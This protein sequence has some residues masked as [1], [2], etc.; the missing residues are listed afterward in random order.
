MALRVELKGQMEIFQAA[1]LVNGA[2]SGT[3]RAGGKFQATGLV[4][5]ATSGTERAGGNFS[6]RWAGQLRCEWN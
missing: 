6:G 3:K 5:G 1:G 4:T 2:V